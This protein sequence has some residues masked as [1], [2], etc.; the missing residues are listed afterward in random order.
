MIRG[1]LL[2]NLRAMVCSSEKVTSMACQ[3]VLSTPMGIELH[4]DPSLPNVEHDSG[5]EKA[6]SAN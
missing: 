2:W 3:Q 6:S 1:L 5:H 4:K